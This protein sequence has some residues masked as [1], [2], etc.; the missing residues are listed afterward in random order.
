M[1]S[2]SK[3]GE[4]GSTQTTMAVYAAE[5]EDLEVQSNGSNNNSILLAASSTEKTPDFFV[6][7]KVKSRKRNE[8]Y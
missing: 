6:Q 4:K 7:P 8:Y 5:N 1:W 3:Y 2:S